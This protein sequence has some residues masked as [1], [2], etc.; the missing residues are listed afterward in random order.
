[1]RAHRNPR[2]CSGN[3]AAFRR[4]A[5]GRR[6][7]GPSQQALR[8]ATSLNPLP[9]ANPLNPVPSATSHSANRLPPLRP[10]ATGNRV[11]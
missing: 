4:L 9:T 5:R 6:G 11:T 2:A 7:S 1:M 8:A 10:I 3:A